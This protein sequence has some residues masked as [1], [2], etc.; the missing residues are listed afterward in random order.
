MKLDK[1]LFLSLFKVES[2]LGSYC[3]TRSQV[4]RLRAQLATELRLGMQAIAPDSRPSLFP[5]V[6]TFVTKMPTGKEVGDFLGLDIGGTN[7]RIV[8]LNLSQASGEDKFEQKLDMEFYDVPAEVRHGSGPV[9]FGFFA[10]CIKQFLEKKGLGKIGKA[11]P[12]GFTFS[13]GFEV[14][15][16]FSSFLFKDRHIF[17]FTLKPAICHRPW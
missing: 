8:H 6:N 7:L 14:R 4:D 5:M 9:F 2:L 12:L 3:L 17:P 15:R 11:L 16:L 13:F 1:R 10:T